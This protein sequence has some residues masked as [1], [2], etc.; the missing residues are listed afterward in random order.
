MRIAIHRFSPVAAMM[1]LASLSLFGAINYGDLMQQKVK[2]ALGGDFKDYQWL[3]YPTNNF[4]LVTAFVL[5]KPRAKPSDKNEWCATFTCLGMEDKQMPT[6]PAEILSVAGYADTGE[7]GGQLILTDEEKKSLAISAVL[8]AVFRLLG[9]NAGVGSTSDIKTELTM[10]PATKR[11]LKKQKMLDYINQLPSS[12]KIK[13]AFDQNRLALVVADVVIDTMDITLT[14]NKDKNANLDA[15]LNSNVGNVLGSGS[16]LTVK[17]DSA[18]SGVYHLKIER[19]VIVARLTL[20][21]PF[22]GRGPGG[23]TP[24][25]L[26][27]KLFEWTGWIPTTVTAASQKHTASTH[28]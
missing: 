10:G 25:H 18:A 5:P 20:T 21:Q 23:T 26:S 11:F 14:P 3:S 12:N 4:G 16:S 17:V 1:L 8:P 19:P 7:G 6:T 28:K 22:E 27:G 15:K 13:E 9:L 2:T 24:P